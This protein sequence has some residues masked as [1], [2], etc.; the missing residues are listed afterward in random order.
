MGLIA[1]WR[2][3]DDNDGYLYVIKIKLLQLRVVVLH[4]FERRLDIRRVQT[5]VSKHLEVRVFRDT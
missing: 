5:L 1:V 4:L 2:T 3:W